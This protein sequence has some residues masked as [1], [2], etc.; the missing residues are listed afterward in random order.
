VIVS[1]NAACDADPLLA[2]AIIRE[3]G[4]KLHQDPVWR[5]SILSAPE[6]LGIDAIGHS[7]LT[8]TSWINTAPGEQ[9]KVSREFWL[10]LLQNLRHE[11]IRLDGAR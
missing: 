10:R 3:N 2:L 4:Q 6:V 1:V 7:G 9:W 11:G 8:I 5:P